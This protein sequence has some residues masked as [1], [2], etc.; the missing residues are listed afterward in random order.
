[1]QTLGTNGR[2]APQHI[3]NIGP[4]TPYSN[5]V[6]T[7]WNAA[8]DVEAIHG[9]ASF[10]YALIPPIPHRFIGHEFVNLWAELNMH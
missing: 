9:E 5:K 8:S 3:V 7:L 6:Q 1:M 10:M 2:Y 4:P